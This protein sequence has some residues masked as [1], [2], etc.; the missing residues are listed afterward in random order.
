MLSGRD[1]QLIVQEVKERKIAS[2]KVVIDTKQ[3]GL[4]QISDSFK[5][6]IFS[7]HQMNRI[8]FGF[9]FDRFQNRATYVVN[10]DMYRDGEFVAKD[11]LGPL[12]D[13]DFA[14]GEPFQLL[15]MTRPNKNPEAGQLGYCEVAQGNV[16]IPEWYEKYESPFF[17]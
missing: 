2:E 3:E 8:K 1:F 6:R 15:I 17:S 4:P 14:L 13:Q 7:Q 11:L 10:S 12:P 16:D 9:F 5:F